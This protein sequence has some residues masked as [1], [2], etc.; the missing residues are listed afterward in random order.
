[1]TTTKRA[2]AQPEVTTPSNQEVTKVV[3]KSEPQAD[4][5]NEVKTVSGNVIVRR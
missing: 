2:K 4:T 1:M 3:T 5:S